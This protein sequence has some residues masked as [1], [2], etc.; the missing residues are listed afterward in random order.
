MLNFYKQRALGDFV[1]I[2]QWAFNDDPVYAEVTDID[3]LTGI[4]QTTGWGLN[5]NW[6]DLADA[7]TE[8][9]TGLAFTEQAVVPSGAGQPLQTL[10]GL[11]LKTGDRLHFKSDTDDETVA[12]LSDIYSLDPQESVKDFIDFTTNEPAAP[13]AGDRY[14][15]TV[16]GVSSV[17]AQAVTEDYIYQWSVSNGNWTEIIPDVGTTLLN[18][19]AGTMMFFNGADWVNLGTI[20]SH[21]NTSGK[22]GGIVGEFYHLTQAQH[23]Y[24]TSPIDHNSLTSFQ[25]GAVNEY[26]HFTSAEH[27]S[28]LALISGG[29]DHNSLGSIQGGAINEYYHFTSAEHTKLKDFY[30]YNLQYVTAGNIRI[31]DFN[32]INF[33]SS[34]DI[35]ILYD[36]G[37]DVFSLLSLSPYIEFLRMKKTGQKDIVF[38][39]SLA[40]VDVRIRG[41]VDNNLFNTDASQNTI[42][43]GKVA[44]P[45]YKLDISGMVRMDSRFVVQTNLIYADEV[46]NKLGIGTI[47]PNEKLTVNG[48]LSLFEGAAPSLTAG[49]GKIY[50]KSSDKKPYFMDST[51]LET[52]IIASYVYFN[53]TATGD[54]TFI[55]PTTYTTITGI[56]RTF[57]L[58]EVGTYIVTMS[59]S[60][61]GTLQ[62]QQ[63]YIALHKNGTIITESRRKIDWFSGL[64]AQDMF[65]PFHTQAIVTV[66]NGDT[67]D[68]KVI[69]TSGDV[70]VS[71]RNM[72]FIK[73]A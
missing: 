31:P 70:V 48:V 28:L 54:V 8:I 43:I 35:Q 49:Y 42:G 30:T 29:I 57:G 60:L 12:F 18:E 17:T 13:S 38:N 5:H 33:G 10:Q 41:M 45:V 47:T 62:G 4:Q 63:N 65:F 40:D 22:Q 61:Q 34:D 37:A 55:A 24:L 21:N 6:R 14:I 66:A 73:L 25:G 9:H 39:Q 36:G 53:V 3:P 67:V 23:T 7:L 50:V 71:D 20:I 52:G 69:A 59:S 27:T 2:G 68:V 64:Q 44:D 32:T 26:Y 16:T 11:W 56:T 15:N 1:T 58:T 51:G 46:N 19:A 72:I